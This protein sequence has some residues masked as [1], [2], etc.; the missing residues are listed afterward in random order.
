MSL[1]SDHG[2]PSRPHKLYNLGNHRCE[3]L[4][5]FIEVLES[6]VGRKAVKEMQEMQ[7][8]DV[9]ETYADIK[10]SIQELGFRP[11]TTIDEGL[12]K[13]VAWFRK[14]HGV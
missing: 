6:A 7:P 3:D 14:Y 11:R 8:G 9:P 12:P 4:T 10:S 1:P 5:H 2:E 13:F